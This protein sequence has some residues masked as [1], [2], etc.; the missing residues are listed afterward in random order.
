MTMPY[1]ASEFV[2]AEL[3]R[4]DLLLHRQVLRLRARYQLSLDE[5]RGLYVSDSHVDSLVREWQS[6]TSNNV[7]DFSELDDRAAAMR[8]ENWDALTSG[9]PWKSLASQ[10]NLSRFEMDVILLAFAPQLDLKYEVIYAYLNNDVSRKWPT[11]DFPLQLFGYDTPERIR[12][13][14]YLLPH[15]PL[16]RTGLLQFVPET[17]AKPSWLAQGFS[18][19]HSAAQYLLGHNVL[20]THLAPV[21][22]PLSTT[23]EW[24]QLRVSSAMQAR[25]MRIPDSL[26]AS[27]DESPLYIFGGSSPAEKKLAVQAICR[28]LRM[29]LLQLDL[30]A[31]QS[32]ADP[33][34]LFQPLALE[35]LLRPASLYVVNTESLWDSDSRAAA[36]AWRFL[37]S[38]TSGKTPVFVAADL[39]EQRSA[40]DPEAF[41]KYESS[42][43]CITIDFAE[44]EYHER[45][46]I[47]EECLL[48]AATDVAPAAID[49]LA[50]RFVFS[51]RQVQDTIRTAQENHRL[52]EDPTAPLHEEDL[53]QAAR[54]Q[55]GH[56]LGSL[57]P[58]VQLVHTWDD[59]VLPEATLRQVL[60]T[61]A[62][63][64]H[65]HIVYANWGF[66]QRLAVSR[67]L[68]I[69]FAGASGTGKTMT[70]SVVARDLGL[71]LYKIDLSSVVSKFIG[72]TE[73]NLDRI[74][75]AAH[76]SNAIL[77][78]DEADALFGKRSEV[79]DAHDRYAN[80]EVAYL[81][82]KMEEHD[83]AVILASNLSRN[84]DQAFSRRMHYV[85]EFPLPAETQRAQLWRGMM[86]PQAPIAADVDF[87]F[88]ARQFPI[89][90]GDIKNVILA[91]AFL[92]A[93]DGQR[94]TMPHLVDAMR[95]QSIKR[96]K[97]PAAA[98]FKQYH[99]QPNRAAEKHGDKFLAPVRRNQE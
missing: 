65:Q 47:W 67:G 40:V 4:L 55:S 99:A 50:S 59:L 51:H 89:S 42:R 73:K 56:Q 39:K 54:S 96:G 38:L 43:R 64:R 76:S 37:I 86:P 24:N 74:F 11:L 9:S 34:K 3:A 70:A 17:F 25:L 85:V 82:Q 33:E 22:H 12:L 63:I 88:L 5:F 75:R 44:L 97:V 46:T 32:A 7:P 2:S 19:N 6:L 20:D 29:P 41:S 61:A 98:D 72:E 36:N 84:I 13:R 53:L 87:T 77:F 57:A 48:Q 95:Q 1:D 35:I 58:K 26:R 83:G 68:K 69:L 94:I 62:A 91:A 92:A 23:A 28:D 21:L 14:S 80:I 71:D 90:G 30:R 60:D 16:F 8:Q 79:N 15:A 66:G 31:A 18:L 81:L 45:R 10:L 52:S 49:A 27:T 93:Q 78:F